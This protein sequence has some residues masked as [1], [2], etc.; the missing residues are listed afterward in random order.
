MEQEYILVIKHGALGDIVI[1]TAGFAAIRKAHPQAHTVLLTTKPYAELLAGSPYFNEIWVDSKPKFSRA[2][3][4]RLRAM[5]NSY[6]WSWV[7]DLQTSQR[8]TLYQWLFKRPWPRI[9]N[10]SRWVSHPRPAYRKDKHALVNL[11][12]QLAVAGLDAGMP[13]LS[14]M[15]GDTGALALPQRY[16]LLVPGGAPHRPEKRWPD[17]QYASLAQELVAKGITPVLVGTKAEEE[18]LKSIATRVPHT[19]NLCGKTSIAQLA[20]L[21]RGAMLAVGN[22]TGPMHVIAAAGCP[23][24]VI[25]S[26]ASD[27]VRSSPV[28]HVSIL[29]E[30]DLSQLT[31]DRVLVSL[32]P[33]MDRI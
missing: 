2:A 22:D 17:Q 5:L 6:R 20:P 16:A 8:T 3:V 11:Q 28:G 4:G 24:T 1:A 27:P 19:I 32:T 9:S 14:W 7:Y 12:N 31:V 18:V 15:N 26:H 25:F 10:A 13:D 23:S 30:K 21:A 29:R 33:L